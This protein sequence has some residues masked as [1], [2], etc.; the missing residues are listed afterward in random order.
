MSDLTN[1]HRG[2]SPGSERRGRTD[3]RRRT[4]HSLIAGNF[5]PRR[6]GPRR[7][8]DGSI[9]STDWHEPR[10]L[11][12]GLT[13]V[14]LSVADALLTLRLI[15]HGALEANPFMAVFLKY[16]PNRFAAV[17]VGLT[18]GGVLILTLVAKVRAFGRLPVG[19][20]L[21]ALLGAYAGLVAYEVWLLRTIANT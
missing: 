1:T 2:A 17:K 12:I 4:I 14:L 16:D 11:A 8:R 15:Q 6:Q 19:A 9:A 18:A 13:I 10:W 21:Y 7:A 5:N 20:I 3:R